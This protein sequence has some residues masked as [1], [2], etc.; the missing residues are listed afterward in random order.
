MTIRLFS[1]DFE[2]TQFQTDFSYFFY[3]M[4]AQVHAFAVVGGWA[5]VIMLTVEYIAPLLVAGESGMRRG[6]RR[7]R[8]DNKRGHPCKA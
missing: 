2:A 7:R 8:F 1:T 3:E 4:A 6:K 5:S